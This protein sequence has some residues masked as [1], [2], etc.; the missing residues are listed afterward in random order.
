MRLR[1]S[2]LGLAGSV[3]AYGATGGAGSAW[4]S[5]LQSVNMTPE[6]GVRVVLPEESAGSKLEQLDERLNMGAL[7]VLEGSSAAASRYGFVPGERE[8]TVRSVVDVHDTRMP[9]IWQESVRVPVFR[10]P[11]SAL[12]FVRERWENAPLAAGT[13]VGNGRVL[14]LA[15][16][17]GAT[18]RERYPYLIQALRDL[19]VGPP[20]T[21]KRLW[22]FFDSSYR[23]RADIEYLAK[24]W[25]R[26]GVAALHIAAW[27]F[28]EADE[29]R[30]AYLRA[31]IGACHK[32]AIVVYAWLELPHVSER[33]WAGHPEWREKTAFGTDAQLDWRKLMN[34]RNPDCVRAVQGGVADLLRRFDWDGVNLAELYFESLE[35][36]ENGSRF[37]PMNADVR[38]E[39]Q[40][41]GGFD[42]VELFQTSGEKHWS[43]NASG[44]IQFLTYRA[45]LSH[46][47]QLDWIGFVDALRVELKHLDLVLTHVDDLLDPKMKEKIGADAKSLLPLLDTKDF[48]FLVEDP[49]PLWSMGPGRYSKMA[50][51]YAPFVKSKGRLA[52]DINV[53]DRYQDVYPTKQQ[54]GVELFQE[55]HVASGSFA[56]VCL[57]FESSIRRTDWPLIS[58]AAAQVQALERV[59]SRV[60][61]RARTPLGVIWKGPVKVNGA[62]WPVQDSIAAW[63][64]AGEHVLEEGAELPGML[65]LDLNAELKA[66]SVR[67]NTLDFAYESS[68]RALAQ[69]S[70]APKVLLVDGQRV[71]PK[72]WVFEDM[73]ILVLPKGQHVVSVMGE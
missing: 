34:L 50:A 12:V 49:A 2:L 72:I 65:L 40:A 47:M 15:T 59:E 69:L 20:V 16:G 26:N 28:F 56:R 17:P 48:T 52:V 18:G 13:A 36:H 44:L 45:T 9:V 21:S 25:R 5:I 11:D 30:D 54:V 64:P 32:N 33:F 1:I 14:W 37:T 22:M 4:L 27:H 46:K 10:V 38:R 43:R 62:P 39:F 53:V 23:L 70:K 31:L 73:W 19:G 68:T 6:H 24:L 35:G 3:V 42:P 58:A 63:L 71:E 60:K 55:M 29:Q 7:V 66:A 41:I 8:V 67:G 57:Y 51:E 61:V